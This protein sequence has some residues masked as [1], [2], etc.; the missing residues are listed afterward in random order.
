VSAQDI[1][2]DIDALERRALAFTLA[3]RLTAW[4][5]DEGLQH[6]QALAQAIDDGDPE[7]LRLASLTATLE[8]AQLE[9]EYIALFENGPQRCPIHETEY[10]RM[11]GMAKGNELADIAGFYAAFGME[12]ADA[13]AAKQMGDHLA[14]EL[15][16]YATLLARQAVMHCRADAEGLFVVEDARKKFLA[17]HLGRLSSAVASQP[18]V[19]Q[20]TTFGP[21]LA[22]TDAL[23]RAECARLG[24]TPAPLDFFSSLSEP[25]ELSCGGAVSARP[26]S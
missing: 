11:R 6:A 26:A 17:D 24:V 9:P 15:E 3:S 20:S 10:G 16:F 18:S 8:R 22:A 4:P 25:E 13:P 19:H 1:S 21:L 23:V 7:E 5:D 14:V 2:V 12:R